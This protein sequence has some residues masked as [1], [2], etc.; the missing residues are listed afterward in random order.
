[1]RFD[2]FWLLLAW[3]TELPVSLTRVPVTSEA[4]KSAHTGA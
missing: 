3:V 2:M 4:I 1:V